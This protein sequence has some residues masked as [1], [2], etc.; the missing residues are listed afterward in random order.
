MNAHIAGSASGQLFI[1]EGVLSGLLLVAAI[2]ILRAKKN[3][4]QSNVTLQFICLSALF[5]QCAHVTFDVKLIAFQTQLNLHLIASGIWLLALSRVLAMGSRRPLS[6]ALK[7]LLP[8]V[9]ILSAL[10]STNFIAPTSLL[11]GNAAY[12]QLLYLAP[13]G[14]IVLLSA[15]A[16]V[17]RP[18][19]YIANTRP[20][21][22]GTMLMLSDE[23]L[24]SPAANVLHTSS[25]LEYVSSTLSVIAAALF[26]K[27]ALRHPPRQTFSL[28][29]KAAF[30]SATLMVVCLFVLLLVLV[31]AYARQSSNQWA[32]LLQFSTLALACIGLS[33]ITLSNRLRSNIR[34]Y[35]E[36]NFFRHKYDY[37]SVWLNLIHKLSSAS[38]ED[39]FFQLGLTAVGSIFD[40]NGGALWL[41][42]GEQFDL[43]AQWN[44]NFPTNLDITEET[45]FIRPFVEEEWIYAVSGSGQKEHDRHLKLLPDWLHQIDD[46]WVIAPLVIGNKLVGF[47]L[48]THQ[49]HQQTLIWEDIDVIKSAGRQL[50][51]Y[52]VRQQSAEELAE[53]KQFDAY[54]KLTAF[55]MHDLKNLIAQQALVVENAQKHKENPAF[56]EDAIRTIDNSVGR[57]SHLL[58]RLQRSSHQPTSRSISVKF[59]VTEAIRKSADRQPI[60][61]LRSDSI[62]A[63]VVADQDQ[64]IMILMHLIRNAQDATASDGFIDIDISIEQSTV[65]IDVEDNGCGMD[66]EFLE[67]RLFKPFES[68][69]SSMG[70]GIGAYQVREFI[71]AMGGKIHV[72]SEVDVGTTVCMQLPIAYGETSAA[73]AQA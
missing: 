2:S 60:P 67:S 31:D 26:L 20:F 13:T 49:T 55:I 6:R 36:K 33:F 46:I 7:I 48:L 63:F 1:A 44:V 18:G 41:N 39:D 3:T 53:S 23:L 71:E 73:R 12:T 50:A 51:S 35:I 42:N 66:R 65:K 43:A 59:I 40:A 45:P 61:T 24:S 11:L 72:S 25:L 10:V 68:T 62:D 30:Y 15:Y 54:N 8:L 32:I 29:R 16:L 38:D 4:P 5:L 69:K 64:I 34:V 19:R 47:F 14:M 37:R 21:L 17:I 28:S 58:K 27:G 52:I 9:W 70:M 56:V 22:W 57:M